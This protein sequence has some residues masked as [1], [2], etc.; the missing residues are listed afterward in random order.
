MCGRL[1]GGG[2]TMDTDESWIPGRQAREEK[3]FHEYISELRR[4]FGGMYNSQ[5]LIADMGSCLAVHGMFGMQ[6]MYHF[7]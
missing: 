6:S 5:R 4:R 1:K 2:E 3:A 7:K